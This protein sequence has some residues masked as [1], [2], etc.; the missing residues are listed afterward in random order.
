MTSACGA[1][2]LLRRNASEQ[3]NK[4]RAGKKRLSSHLTKYPAAA[5]RIPQKRALLASLTLPTSR[6]MRT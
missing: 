4:R 3:A 6:P 2:V 1:S 5:P